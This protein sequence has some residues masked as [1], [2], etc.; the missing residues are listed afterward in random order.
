[1][2]KL[3]SE[4]LKP[5]EQITLEPYERDHA[6]VV[7]LYRLVSINVCDQLILIFL[8]ILDPLVKARIKMTMRKKKQWMNN[9]LGKLSST[10]FCRLSVP[11]ICTVLLFL[12]LI[13]NNKHVFETK[14]KRFSFVL[15]DETVV[16]VISLKKNRENQIHI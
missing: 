11:V 6:V 1:M 4:K 7:G 16:I 15:C 3:Q 5:K 8:S 13:K 10:I 9:R 14:K 2:K 12:L